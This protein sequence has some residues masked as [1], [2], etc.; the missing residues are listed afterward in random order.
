MVRKAL[1]AIE[2]VM[3]GGVTICRSEGQWIAECRLLPGCMSQG[4]TKEE[5]LENLGDAIG[6]VLAVLSEEGKIRMD[7]ADDIYCPLCKTDVPAKTTA[8]HDIVEYDGYPE[9]ES[10]N[11]YGVT[12]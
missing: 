8:D 4:D 1:D 12:F 6:G 11:V 5:V 9:L 7:G 2:Q 3:A 10:C